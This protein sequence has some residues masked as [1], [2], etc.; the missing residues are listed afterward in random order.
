MIGERI[1]RIIDEADLGHDIE[2]MRKTTFAKLTGINY[3]TLARMITNEGL[4]KMENVI[5]LMFLG[6]KT[7]QINA[8]WLLFGTGEM[9]INKMYT[10]IDARQVLINAQKE[11]QSKIIDSNTKRIDLL[12]KKLTE[13]LKEKKQST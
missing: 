13:V 9:W 8:N 12:E 11:R 5:K 1:K 7:Q 2:S 10:K 6:K 3:S 4:P